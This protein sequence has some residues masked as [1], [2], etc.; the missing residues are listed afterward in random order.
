MAY[1]TVPNLVDRE[2]EEILD[3]LLQRFKFPGDV[4]ECLGTY[5]LKGNDVS[6]DKI[7]DLAG[8][9]EL[10]KYVG[11]I[12]PEMEREMVEER[13]LRKDW[14]ERWAQ[15]PACSIKRDPQEP[16]RMPNYY[17]SAWEMIERLKA[18][19]KLPKDWAPKGNQ[20]LFRGPNPE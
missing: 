1:I 20:R 18:E 12:T 13:G 10:R 14:I 8:K 4:V 19:G 7:Y 17:P 2:R 6:L 11:G 15:I 3:V 9:G 5:V 16:S